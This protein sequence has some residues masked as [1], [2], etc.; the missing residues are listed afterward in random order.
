MRAAH[1]PMTLHTP[2]YPDGAKMKVGIVSDTSFRIPGGVQEYVRGLHDFLRER[3]VDVQIITSG[4][5]GHEDG[6]RNFASLGK[7]VDLSLLNWRGA[8]SSMPLN[9]APTGRIRSFLRE[10]RFDVLHYAAP[11]AL[12]GSRILRFSRKASPGAANVIAFL[13]YNETTPPAVRLLSP[14]LKRL[15]CS[16]HGRVAI[17][18]PAAEY[19]QQFYPGTYAIIPAG[20]DVRRFNPSVGRIDAFVDG[21]VNI[22]FA[23]RLDR[24]KNVMDMLEVYARLSADCP[25][26][27]LIIVGDGPEGQQA[28][29]FVRDR[30]LQNVAMVGRVG[31]E[32]MPKYYNTCDIFCAPALGQ[33][34][35]GVVLVEAMACGKPVAG[36]R[37]RGYETVVAGSPLNEFLVEPGN[38]SALHQALKSLI[39]DGERRMRLGAESLRLVRER[40]A[41]EVVG[42]RILECYQSC[43]R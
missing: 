31:A 21:K 26:T 10:E 39:V 17:S 19:A 43:R 18:E 22:L 7:T 14:I 25:D 23:G 6:G 37:N 5:R 40:Y 32:E 42:E 12:L 4:E 28:Q 2:S 34:S 24:R 41:W 27:R 20:I 9:W 36:Y 1:S 13:I 3:G 30:H 38:V 15:N 35:F 29:E 11:M 33:E 16:I 8:A